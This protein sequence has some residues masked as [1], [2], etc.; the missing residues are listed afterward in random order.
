LSEIIVE[1]GLVT[2]I[3]TDQ[4]FSY[5]DNI[6]S[7]IAIDGLFGDWESN[8]NQIHNDTVSDT[9]NSN[10]DITKYGS[11]W[12]DDKMNFYLEVDGRLLTGSS[13]P[14]HPLLI[15]IYPPSPHTSLPTTDTDRDGVPDNLDPNPITNQDVDGDTLPDDYELLFL[16][17]NPNNEDTDMDG[18]NDNLDIEPLNPR[19][20]PLPSKIGE[21]I[22]RIFMDIDENSSTGYLIN[23]NLDIEPNE[24]GHD[25]KKVNQFIGADYKIEVT[26]K[27]GNVLNNKLY[28]FN[29]N[30]NWN[31]ELNPD[32]WEYIIFDESNR[33]E[34]LT[35]LKFGKDGYRFETCIDLGNLEEEILNGY[36]VY[37]YSSDWSKTAND[38]SNLLIID[39]FSGSGTLN[40]SHSTI[41]NLNDN[42]NISSGSDLNNDQLY[43]SRDEIPEYDNLLIIIILTFLILV[44]RSY[45][46]KTPFTQPKNNKNQTNP[47]S[48]LK[49]K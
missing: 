20:P 39:E 27:Y 10:I 19:V 21:D 22:I 40:R 48:I 46:F 42:A 25:P 43:G 26:G 44:S 41:N 14:V 24:Y 4:K 30:D 13:A 33:W 47:K 34:Y 37:F 36:R 9:D 23:T 11:V 7:K 35:D 38:H 49:L 45:L 8:S 18:W 1:K 17:T 28:K 5:I 2:K 16:K 29:N 3:I 12:D 15:S 31:P 32:N 6:P